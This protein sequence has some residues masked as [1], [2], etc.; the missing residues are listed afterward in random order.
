MIRNITEKIDCGFEW[1]DI[2]DPH[3]DELDGLAEKYNLHE[4]SVHDCMQP[5]HLPKYEQFKNYTFIIM[6]IYSENENE[7][8]TVQEITN[9]IAIFISEK[10]IITIHRKNWL[11]L[12]HIARMLEE[13]ED[14]NKPQHILV[15]I[16]K[17]G[18]KSYDEPGR[19]ITQ[20]IEYFETQ[21]FLTE[22]KVSLLK[23]LYFIKRKVDVIRRLLLLTNDIVDRV[24]PPQSSS[25]L[26]RDIRDLYIKQKSLFDSL[27][28]NTNQLVN[29]YFNVSSQRTNETMRVLTIFSVFFMP[30]TFIVGVYGM[31]FQFM[32]E[33]RLKWAYP[34]VMASMV[35]IVVIIYIW[36]KRKKW[37]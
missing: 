24:D 23:G 9:K 7:A 31:N 28:E 33:L 35:V 17:E 37:L 22:R 34:V 18:L 3:P 10:F 21:V 30:L 4:E 16:V 25:A 14:C 36:F 27:S 15:E 26:T 20:S 2:I 13:E 6:R 32:P 11:P 1:V 12:H 8:D 19:S 5:G 29:L